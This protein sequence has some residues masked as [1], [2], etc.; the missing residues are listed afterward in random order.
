MYSIKNKNSQAMALLTFHGEKTSH[1]EW[2]KQFH[3]TSL[4]LAPLP[5]TCDCE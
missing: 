4:A 5:G 3:T 2:K 1:H